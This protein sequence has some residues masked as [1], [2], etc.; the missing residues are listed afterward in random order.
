MGSA[1]LMVEHE[2]GLCRS[3]TGRLTGLHKV[4]CSAGEL[5]CKRHQDFFVGSD[6][7]VAIPVHSKIGKDMKR[8]F[9]TEEN[10]SFRC[11]STTTSSIST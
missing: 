2:N 7:G 1:F 5:V 9:D 8:N 6:G 3:L 11:T 4:L 10:S